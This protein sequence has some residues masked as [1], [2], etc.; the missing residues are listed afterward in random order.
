MGP[1]APENNDPNGDD[2]QGLDPEDPNIDDELGPDPED[3]P[4]ENPNTPDENPS[5]PPT[6]EGPSTGDAS[7]D[8]D[9]KTRPLCYL[10]G[11]WDKPDKEGPSPDCCRIYED[12][13]FKGRYFDFCATKEEGIKS[14]DFSGKG[15]AENWQAS[16]DVGYDSWANEVSSYQ[17]GK[18]VRP[19]LTDDATG[20]KI[21]G[22]PDSDNPN[23]GDDNNLADKIT[24]TQRDHPTPA[25]YAT[26]YQE[27]ECRGTQTMIVAETTTDYGFSSENVYS[28][29]QTWTW[30]AGKMKSVFIDG[31]MDMEVYNKSHFKADAIT[32][33]NYASEGKCIEIKQ[34][35]LHRAD[36]ESLRLR[37]TT[38]PSS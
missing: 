17:C 12:V 2:E 37:T 30:V 5:T 33:K 38:L 3:P 19:T 16:E 28:R 21:K 34:D 14:F 7:R 20:N 35:F 23:L 27:L 9:Y 18:N 29:A 1:P 25:G 10:G 36:T 13:D 8:E 26:L 11:E 15:D 6:E 22:G 24:V 31:G 32:L 4:A